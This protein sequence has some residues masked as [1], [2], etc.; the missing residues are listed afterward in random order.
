MHGR[1]RKGFAGL[2]LLAGALAGCGQPASV[3]PGTRPRAPGNP[4]ASDAAAIAAGAEL[5]AT[6]ACSACHGA[7]AR[8]GMGPSLRNDVWI[9]G[10]DDATLFD[11]VRG[12][13]VALRASGR[14]RLA[15]EAQYGDMPPLAGAVDEAELWKILAWVRSPPP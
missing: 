6:R 8:G 5:Y 13:S 15:R 1:A 2:V 10:S 14:E 9:Y 3:D 12:G 11:L 7:D 4:Y